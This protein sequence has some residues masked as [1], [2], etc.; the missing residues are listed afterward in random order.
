MSRNQEIPERYL[1]LL[2]F[3]KQYKREH[4]GNSPSYREMAD[5]MG[6][7]VGGGV[8][9]ALGKLEKFGLIKFV[10]NSSESIRNSRSLELVGYEVVL[11]RVEQ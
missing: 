5:Y 2:E 10:R 3:I 11:R 6:V 4:Q 9:Y 7:S 8:M 1:E